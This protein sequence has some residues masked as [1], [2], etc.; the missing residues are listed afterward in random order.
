MTSSPANLPVARRAT[1]AL[2]SAVTVAAIAH[3]A[4][5]LAFFVAGGATPRVCRRS[6]TTSSSRRCSPSSCWPSSPRWTACGAGM[7]RFPPPSS[8]RPILASLLGTVVTL[9]R[10]GTPDRRRH[11]RAAAGHGGRPEPRLHR[12]RSPSPRPPSAGA[13]GSRSP[14]TRRRRMRPGS[15]RVALVRA[16]AQ[17]SRRGAGHPHRA[18]DRSTPTSPRTSGTATCRP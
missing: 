2:V 7:W 16:P 10:A 13:S 17:Q 8:S 3:V 9:G 4:T 14:A 11:H 12:G 1:A 6:A 15:G 5:V 18:R